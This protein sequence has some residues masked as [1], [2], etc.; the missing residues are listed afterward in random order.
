MKLTKNFYIASA[1]AFLFVFFMSIMASCV[2]DRDFDTYAA[3]DATFALWA[4][5]D[6]INIADEA[7]RLNDGDNLAHYK[8]TSA[9]ARI[10]KTPGQIIVSFGNEN[11]S[12]NVNCLCNDG[13]NR[14]G[15]IFVNY[16][17]NYL[18]SGETSVITF[19][20][21]F[22][23][24]TEMRGSETIQYTGL[25]DNGVPTFDV[26]VDGTFDILDSL[27]AL[28]YNANITRTWAQGAGTIEFSDDLY[29]LTGTA[30]GVNIY[31]NNYAFNTLEPVKKPTNIICRYFTQGILEVQ[32][33]GRT[34]R[35][36]DFGDGTCTSNATV[37][38]DG[39]Q[40]NIELR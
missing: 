7:A 27:G 9:C 10:V 17:G 3:E 12:D 32:P 11:G 37:T 28:T 15:R 5:D 40:H 8:T 34:F 38:I 29:E 18:D 14:R 25:N 31:G 1:T 24:D 20:N 6:V 13:R 4:F 19:E 2:K 21:Y 33:Q 26:N 39:K 36:I 23:D 30:Q 16:T 35:S 22:V